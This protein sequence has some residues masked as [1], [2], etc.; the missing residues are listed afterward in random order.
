MEMVVVERPV[1]AV[2]TLSADQH[3]PVRI[4]G[5]DRAGLAGRGGEPGFQV[6]VSVQL[7]PVA[8]VALIAEE[9]GD[10][11]DRGPFAQVLAL[12]VGIAE[13]AAA[14]AGTA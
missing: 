11:A 8:G 1:A 2:G 6:A 7:R 4:V 12:A 14:R 5:E 10:L 9:F 3:A 13:T